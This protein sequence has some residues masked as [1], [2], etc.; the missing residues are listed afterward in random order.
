[1]QK[2]I[3]SII[4]SYMAWTNNK[5]SQKV[6]KKRQ[7]AVKIP[8]ISKCNFLQHNYIKYKKGYNWIYTLIT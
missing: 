4:F 8:F 3:E 6:S 5:K 7:D 1:M 2:W